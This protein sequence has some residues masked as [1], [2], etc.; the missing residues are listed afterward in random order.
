MKHKSSSSNDFSLSLSR[1]KTDSSALARWGSKRVE[2]KFELRPSVS[3]IAITSL[4]F[5]EA[6]PFAAFASLLVE[7][8]ARLDLVIEEV[9]ELGKVAKFREFSA[10]DDDDVSVIC[11]KEMVNPA[12]NHLPSHAVDC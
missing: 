1:V 9:E 5:A 4:E 10:G 7:A 3:K 2:T 6:L 12:E 11:H 8:V